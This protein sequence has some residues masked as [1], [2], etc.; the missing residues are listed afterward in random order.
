MTT[1]EIIGL[2]VGLI[3]ASLG[4]G[5]MLFVLFTL[6]RAAAKKDKQSK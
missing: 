3:G 2:V 5:A 6:V 4:L 1:D